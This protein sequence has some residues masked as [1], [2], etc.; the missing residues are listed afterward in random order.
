MIYVKVY[1]KYINKLIDQFKLNINAEK[2]SVGDR[3][4]CSKKS[5]TSVVTEEYRIKSIR[6][7]IAFEGGY[8]EDVATYKKTI[9][10][11]N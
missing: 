6:H 4:T 11:V 2:L 8:E 9:V 3:I 5:G 1:D 10:E 7:E